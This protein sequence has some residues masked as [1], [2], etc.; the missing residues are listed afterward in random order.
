MVGGVKHQSLTEVCGK[1]I[2]ILQGQSEMMLCSKERNQTS[3]LSVTHQPGFYHLSLGPTR[4]L[5]QRVCLLGPVKAYRSSGVSLKG[6]KYAGEHIH[7]TEVESYQGS[8]LKRSAGS[9]RTPTVATV[10]SLE[11]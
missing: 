5:P 10:H 9:P 2:K 11:R 8:T 4:L 6:P 1:V 3:G 7:H